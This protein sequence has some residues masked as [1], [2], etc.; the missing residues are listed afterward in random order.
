MNA[1]NAFGG[2]DDGGGFKVKRRALEHRIMNLSY[3]ELWFFV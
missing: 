2:W 1:V 3:R